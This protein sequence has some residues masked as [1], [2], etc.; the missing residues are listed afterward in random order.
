MQF[1]ADIINAKVIRPKVTEVTAAGAAYLAGLATGYWNG[2]DEIKQQW[3]VDYAFEP[4]HPGRPDLVKGWDIA[5][6][7]AKSCTE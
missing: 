3:Q 7:A 5:V 1:Q 6:K 4:Q 2:L